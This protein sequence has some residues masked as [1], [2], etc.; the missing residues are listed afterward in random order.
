MNITQTIAA[1]LN[2]TAAQVEAAVA[3]LDEG[4]TVPFIAR[5]RKEATGGLDEIQ[6]R[7]LES[8]LSYLRE[9][10]EARGGVVKA[11]EEEG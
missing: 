5:Y 7:A 11:I 8:R 6:L 10:A 2:A 4:S 1:E 3:L 9:L